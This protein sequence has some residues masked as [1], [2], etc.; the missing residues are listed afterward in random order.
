MRSRRSEPKS[1]PRRRCLNGRRSHLLS[2]VQER[3][4]ASA[5]RSNRLL[6]RLSLSLSVSSFLVFFFF[7]LVRPAI[8]AARSAICVHACTHATDREKDEKQRERERTAHF[9]PVDRE[10]PEFLGLR[11]TRYVD[12]HLLEERAEEDRFT[13]L[14]WLD[15]DYDAKSSARRERES[16][17]AIQVYNSVIIYRRDKIR[18]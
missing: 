7:A 17:C 1:D 14:L 15:V 4:D 2:P 6:S 5:C 16:N 11:V 13:R 12:A 10:R 8:L 3:A 18:R 9:S